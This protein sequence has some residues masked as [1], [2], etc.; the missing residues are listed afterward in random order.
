METIRKNKQKKK[1]GAGGGYGWEVDGVKFIKI[2][3]N[4]LGGDSSR[5]TSATRR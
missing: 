2:L 3:I 5:E 4:H 1:G